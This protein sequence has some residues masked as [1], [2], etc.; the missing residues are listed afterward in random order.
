MSE[1]DKD[2]S[3][4]RKAKPPPRP[5]LR[6]S[7]FSMALG[8]LRPSLL[9]RMSTRTWIGDQDL[10]GAHKVTTGAGRNDAKVTIMNKLPTCTP[11]CTPS[12]SQ[13]LSEP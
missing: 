1:S 3:L 13:S 2:K 5:I 10:K 7:R 12:H 8:S 9:R 11:F 4:G 6:L